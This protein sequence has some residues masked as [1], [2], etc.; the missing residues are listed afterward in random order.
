MAKK[1][2]KQSATKAIGDGA[3]QRLIIEMKNSPTMTAAGVSAAAGMNAG[4]NIPDEISTLLANAGA[5]PVADFAPVGL[6]AVMGQDV[7]KPDFSSNSRFEVSFD[8]DDASIIV[9]AYGDDAAVD[10]LNKDARVKGVF[11]DVEISPCITCGNSRPMGNTADVAR[12]VCAERMRANGMDGT[13]VL[14]AIVDNGINKDHLAARGIVPVMDSGRSWVRVAGMTPFEA[15]VDHGTMCAYD[16]L[17][18]APKATLLDIQ[19]LRGTAGGF[20]SEAVRAYAHLQTIML[21]PRRLGE[22]R[23]LVV[24]NSWGMYHPSGDFPVGHPGNYSDNPNHPFNKAVAALEA[25]GADILF[26]AGNCGADCPAGACQGVVTNTI[27]G[28]NGHSAVLTVAGV[29]IG[30]VRVGYSSQG[31]GR[32]STNK[33]D[34]AG[35][36]HFSGSG[37]YSADN[38]TSAACPV[39]AGVVAAVRT[40]KPHQPGN[41]AVSPHAIREL[42]RMTAEDISPSG[43]DFNTGFGVISGCNLIDRILLM[44]RIVRPRVPGTICDRIPGLC[45]PLPRGRPTTE[46][47]RRY[48]QYCNG[49]PVPPRDFPIPIPP[50]PPRGFPPIPSQPGFDANAQP[51]EMYE[52]NVEDMLAIMWQ[53]GYDAA[54]EDAPSRGAKSGGGCNCS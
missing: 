18:A 5:T 22:P 48:P 20:L 17:I 14:L 3:P 36:T 25:L 19:L 27:Y 12:L 40:R 4:A 50:I 2:T 13:G 24:N 52:P 29:D 44:D 49:F 15:P 53:M 39:V 11:A 7:M 33:P 16:A 8:A 35:F 41:P 43:F 6:A 32:L 1:P 54:Q 38:G 46:F 37:V 42:V 51:S 47:C 45:D 9:V 23:S 31:P 30:K 26:A 21:A 10:Y 28:A 34:I